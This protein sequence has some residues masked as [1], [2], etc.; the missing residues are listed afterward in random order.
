MTAMM[1]NRLDKTF[2]LFFFAPAAVLFVISCV[3]ILLNCALCLFGVSQSYLEPSPPSLW[4]TMR[5]VH[6]TLSL[7]YPFTQRKAPADHSFPSASP[8]Y[9]APF[10]NQWPRSVNNELSSSSVFP[11]ITSISDNSAAITPTTSNPFRK[12]WC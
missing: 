7:K 2:F 5:D 1:S 10:P 6:I 11:G 3:L 9:L 8:S 12:R 4:L